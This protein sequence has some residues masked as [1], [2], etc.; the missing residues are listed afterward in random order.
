MF[1]LNV[2]CNSTISIS[3]ILFFFHSCMALI[4]LPC[5]AYNSSTHTMCGIHYYF[6]A[7]KCACSYMN[8]G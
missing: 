1:N 7:Q 3:S 6:V 5:N 8:D 2:P 4:E